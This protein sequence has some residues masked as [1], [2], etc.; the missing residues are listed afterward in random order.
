MRL[1]PRVYSSRSADGKRFRTNI[2]ATAA[3]PPRRLTLV[4]NWEEESKRKIQMASGRTD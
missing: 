3:G 2:R 1:D 4:L